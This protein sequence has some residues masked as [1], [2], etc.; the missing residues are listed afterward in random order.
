MYNL[1]KIEPEVCDEGEQIK[2]ILNI[3]LKLQTLGDVSIRVENKALS[4]V[5]RS[6]LLC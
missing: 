6:P 1:S 5:W 2:T 4:V 3:H